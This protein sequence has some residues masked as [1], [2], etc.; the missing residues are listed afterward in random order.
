MKKRILYLF[1]LVL[2]SVGFFACEDPYA[3]QTVADPTIYEQPAIQDGS[4]AAKVNTN[5]LTITESEFGNSLKFITVT[6]TPALLDT[7]ATIEYEVILSDTENFATF[8]SVDF[9]VSG[10]DLMVDYAQ[11]NDTLLAL[12]ETD[13]EHNAYAKVLG[14]IVKDGTRALYSTTVM[15]FKVTTQPLT[16]NYYEVTPSTWYLVG[17]GGNWDNSVNGLGSSLIPLSVVTGS[18]YNKKDGAGKY[19]YTG[20]FK[21]GSGFKIIHTPGNWDIQWGNK[22]E[23]GIDQPTMSGGQNFGVP[24]DGY[25]TVT[26]NSIKNTCTIESVTLTPDTYASIGVVGALTGWG[27]QPDFVMTP[28]P[29]TENHAWYVTVTIAD[30]ETQFK[31]RV[32]SEWGT[33]WGSTGSSDGDPL[34]QWVGLGSPGGKNILGTAGTYVIMFNDIDKCYWVV[35]K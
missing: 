34:Y 17:L 20:Y 9:Q 21:A 26:L 35:K 22:T 30:A 25:Y 14:Y 1:A 8:K 11:L 29:N 16:K 27:G 10:S 12:N 5:P 2:A 19:T 31:F 13:V 3:N 28:N 4:F 32:N 15:P 33:N 7:A 6:S 23:G 18:E 24:A